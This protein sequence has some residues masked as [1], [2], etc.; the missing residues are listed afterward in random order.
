MEELRREELLREELRREELCREEIMRE[1]MLRY[2]EETRHAIHV[3]YISQA[4]LSGYGPD[5]AIFLRRILWIGELMLLISFLE[6]HPLEPTNYL[7]VF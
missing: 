3:D 2:Q 5:P 7:Q 1:D 4:P 6:M